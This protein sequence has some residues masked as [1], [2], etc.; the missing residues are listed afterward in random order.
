MAKTTSLKKQEPP[1]SNIF[2]LEKIIGRS[3]MGFKNLVQENNINLMITHDLASYTRLIG[4]GQKLEDLL[5]IILNNV[6]TN[7]Q[8]TKVI[9]SIRQLLRFEK[10]LLVEFSIED[11][12]CL[13]HQASNMAYCRSLLTAKKLIEEMEGKSELVVA[14]G[15]NNAFKF[16]LK[17]KV[18]TEQEEQFEVSASNNSLAGKR[19]LLA[20]DNDINQKVIF[21][22]LE[23]QGVIIDIAANGKEA[24]DLFET[25]RD[26]DLVLMDILMPFMDGLQATNYIRKKCCSNVPI[27]AMSAMP[28]PIEQAQCVELGI[29]KYLSKPFTRKELLAQMHHFLDG[30]ANPTR[31]LDMIEKKWAV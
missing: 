27:I 20:E 10:E 21:Q 8:T 28:T 26:Y 24:V 5:K 29:N 25:K 16:I 30:S 9:L 6:L 23:K 13:K 12:G 17:C 11:N 15:N 3:I 14:E 4:D 31:T 7:P 2:E 19:I 22:M 1:D 18:Y